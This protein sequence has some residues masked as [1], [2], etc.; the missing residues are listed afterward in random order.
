MFTDRS[1]V[2]H[3]FYNLFWRN[4]KNVYIYFFFWLT[5]AACVYT[6]YMA[7]DP[8]GMDS[9][10]LAD[11]LLVRLEKNLL[12]PDSTSIIIHNT[13]VTPEF[14][15]PIIYYFFSYTSKNQIKSLVSPLQGRIG[16][17]NHTPCYA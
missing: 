10:F 16:G 17:I 12:L 11:Q 3:L 2:K 1:L 14:S 15:K 6:S 7:A 9:D 8:P 5:L 13:G 4:T